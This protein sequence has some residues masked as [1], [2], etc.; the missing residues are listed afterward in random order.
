MSHVLMHQYIITYAEDMVK[1]KCYNVRMSLI[2]K[3]Y[4]D[5]C[6]LLAS[7][8]SPKEADQLLQ[9]LL[10]PQEI[11]ALAER[12]QLIQLLAKGMPQR[13]IADTLKISISTITRG[14]RA[15]QYG[16][17]GFKKFLEKL[18]KRGAK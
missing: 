16:S 4:K 17:G 3:H 8:E 10:T 11:D 13:E 5:L 9:D 2:D 18:G 1:K 7:I 6:A 12:W 15:L 14:S